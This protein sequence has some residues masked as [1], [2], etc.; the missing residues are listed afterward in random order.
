MRCDAF[1]GHRQDSIESVTF[2]IARGAG[3]QTGEVR[4]EGRAM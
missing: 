2:A 1:V 3:L 4:C